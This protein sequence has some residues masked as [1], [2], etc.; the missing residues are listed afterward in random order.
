MCIRDSHRPSGGVRRQPEDA[1]EGERCPPREPPVRG[2][3]C[4]HDAV[5]DCPGRMARV[6]DR[7]RARGQDNRG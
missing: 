4:A 3:V 6:R 7:S 5:D 1:R 2:R